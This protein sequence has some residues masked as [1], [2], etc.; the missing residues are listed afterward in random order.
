MKSNIRITLIEPHEIMCNLLIPKT[1]I[2][3]PRQCGKTESI[4]RAIKEVEYYK[5]FV[6]NKDIMDIKYT[7][8]KNVH[9]GK[10]FNATDIDSVAY[11]IFVDDI[12]MMG[13]DPKSKLKY[14]PLESPGIYAATASSIQFDLIQHLIQIRRFDFE[15]ICFVDGL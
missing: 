5:V 12:D 11:K 8:I 15:R 4:K 10:D 3:A 9:L 7:G 1:L 6:V 14:I 2:V 13:E